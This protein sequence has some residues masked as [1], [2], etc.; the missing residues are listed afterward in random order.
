MQKLSSPIKLINDSF[1]IFF[2]EGNITYFISIYL[3]TVPF[4]ISA[5]IQNSMTSSSLDS[6][7]SGSYAIPIAVIN[8][9]SLVVFLL[10]SAAGI[11]AVKNVVDGNPLRFKE[12]IIFAWKNL[13]G[14]FLLSVLLFLII[15]GGS[16]LFIIPG[17]VFAIWFSF[18]GFIFID[19]GLG[20]KASLSRSREL[21]KGRFWSVFWRLLVFG[22]FFGLFGGIAFY[23]LSLIPYGIGS[24]IST[25]SGAFSIL[26]YYLL[27]KELS[28]Q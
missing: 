11:V 22:L 2:A 12:T 6:L 15:L 5:Y 9:L 28:L 27:Y 17:I 14:F 1:R 4:L 7:E 18:A 23:L 24:I 8:L 16:I 19:Q 3:I 26:P 21:F 25:I 13:W 20:V 10:T